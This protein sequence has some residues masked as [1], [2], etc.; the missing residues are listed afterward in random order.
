[1][2]SFSEFTL[3]NG[4]RVYV[5][6]DT[7]TPLVALNV[8]YNVG[9][10]H[11][12]PDKT[13]FAHLFEHLMFGGSA[14]IPSYD[15]P[16]QKVGGENN[17]F[18]TPDVTNY[19]LTLPAENVETAFWLESDRMLGLSFDP[20]VLKVQQ[21]VVIEE[22]KQRYLNQPYGDV[23]LKL[24]PLAYK[25]HPYKWPT[26]GA[27]ISHIENAT[28]Q[29]VKDFFYTYYVPNNAILVIAG[30]IKLDKAKHLTEKWF[31]PIESGKEHKHAL[32]AEPPQT[33]KRIQ[34]VSAQ[35][36]MN[37]LYK[38][39]HM[40]ERTH[41]DFY[42][43][44]L[45]SDLLGRGQSSRLYQQLVKKQKIFNSI[46]AYVTASINPGLLVVEGKINQGITFE[47]AEQA[48]LEQIENTTN[49]ITDYELQ[50]V[51]NQ[52]ETSIT[53][54][55]VELLNRAMNIAFGANMGNANLI[56]EEVSHI[57]AVSKEQIISNAKP[58][59]TENNCSTLYYGKF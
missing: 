55:E 18:T 48:I 36:P 13:G 16:L 21:K 43:F 17:A 35:V 25:V 28:M 39:W 34:H 40:P 9:S 56:N 32:P 23:W 52:S 3:P 58:Y 45:L 27:E 2:I 26:I 41:K 20:K 33:E 30:N 24:R 19:Y 11:E 37:A 47:Q 10:R 38:A 15:T 46:N 1:M 31:G 49:S 14:N 51:K 53:L 29:D 54:A 12:K 22:Y 57:Q 8:L 4:L 7:T 5:H 50:K 44:D 42:A 6:T 59:L